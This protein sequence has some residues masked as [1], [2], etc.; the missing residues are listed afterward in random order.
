MGIGCV[1]VYQLFL[2]KDAFFKNKDSFNSENEL[3]KEFRDS[4]KKS[5]TKFT[6]KMEDD[7]NEISALMKK[8]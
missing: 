6:K 7:L 3:V 5:G 2:K 1:V 8:H 4:S